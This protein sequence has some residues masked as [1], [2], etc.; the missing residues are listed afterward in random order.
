M[1]HLGIVIAFMLAISAADGARQSQT[2]PGSIAGRVTAS[3]K[4]LDAVSI[5]AFRAGTAK[6]AATATSGA[7]GVYRL[8]PLAQ[9]VYRV[10]FARDGYTPLTRA[11][12][13]VFDGKT[14][15]LDAALTKAK[16]F[17]AAMR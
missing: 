6:P 9:G 3:G 1:R 14:A 16:L 4:P 15:E 11:G 2:D 17:V 10:E 8:A 7:D 5:Q 12:I 13:V